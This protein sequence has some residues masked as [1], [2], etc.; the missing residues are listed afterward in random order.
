MIAAKNLR[1]H[2]HSPG[3]THTHVYLC[4]RMSGDVSGG[5]PSRRKRPWHLFLFLLHLTTKGVIAL[6]R[7]L[8]HRNEKLSCNTK[9]KQPRFVHALHLGPGASAHAGNLD[10]AFWMWVCRAP[11]PPRMLVCTSSSRKLPT[12]STAH[13]GSPPGG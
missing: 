5:R 2:I 1:A 7:A 13:P 9:H 11:M 3:N 8:E 12:T 10:T 6:P 4:V